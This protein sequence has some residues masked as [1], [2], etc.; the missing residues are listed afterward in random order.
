[1]AV[2]ADPEAVQF[3]AEHGGRVYVYA[4]RGGM[5]RVKTMAPDDTSLQFEQIDGDGFQLFVESGLVQPETWWVEY[6]HFPHRHVDV[7]WDGHQ[8]G[9]AVVPP[10]GNFC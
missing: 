5:K 1:V 4:D 7:L 9:G 8:P 10:S 3:I 6:R 2:I